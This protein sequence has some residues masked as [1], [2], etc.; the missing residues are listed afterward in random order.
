MTP[1]KLSG[2]SVKLF[3][4]I[5][6]TLENMHHGITIKRELKKYIYPHFKV[7]KTKGV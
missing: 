6:K 2:Q 3:F 7:L 5:M 1:V 4:K